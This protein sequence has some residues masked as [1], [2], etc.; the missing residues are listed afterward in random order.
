MAE[1]HSSD[2]GDIL[3]VESEG[4][5]AL[6]KIESN[7]LAGIV[8]EHIDRLSTLDMLRLINEED[9]H[10]A[11]SNPLIGEPKVHINDDVVFRQ[12]YCPGCGTLIENEVSVA[13]DAPL[14]D[15]SIAL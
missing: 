2:G 10:V 6:S 7:E 15:I 5:G 1:P 3:S 13:S 8:S 11:E 9:R 12:F 14:M 4:S